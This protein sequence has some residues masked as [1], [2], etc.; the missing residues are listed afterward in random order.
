MRILLWGTGSMSSALALGLNSQ[1]FEFLLHNP[2]RAKAQGLSAR[3]KNAELWKGQK[4]DVVV[5]GFKP[6][7]LS[8]AMEELTRILKPETLVISL[9]AGVKLEKLQSLLGP[10]VIRLMP[11][12]AIAE[13][14]NVISFLS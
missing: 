7:K 5:L 14:L 2:T 6:Q 12:L 3:L 4:F 13:V 9:L 11:N 8:E 10:R 1:G